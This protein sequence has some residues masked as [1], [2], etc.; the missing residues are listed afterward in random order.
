MLFIKNIIHKEPSSLVSQPFTQMLEQRFMKRISGSFLSNKIVGCSS[1]VFKSSYS[2]NSK[3]TQKP[4]NE[5][6]LNR[7]PDKKGND[8]G[9]KCLPV[10]RQN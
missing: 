4:K 9:L 10:L 5:K 7:S 2:N 1:Q 8:M 6:V 3:V